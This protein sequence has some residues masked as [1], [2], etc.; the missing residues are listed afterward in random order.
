MLIRSL[1]EAKMTFFFNIFMFYDWKYH[2]F[3]ATSLF[4][5]NVIF[6]K[7]KFMEKFDKISPHRNAFMKMKMCPSK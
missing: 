1:K 7:I 5:I 3:S 2:P 6:L 4:F